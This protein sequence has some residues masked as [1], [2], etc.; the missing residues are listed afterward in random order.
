MLL[1]KKTINKTTLIVNVD[2]ISNYY[3][4]SSNDIKQIDEDYI[5][6][7]LNLLIKA[8][9]KGEFIENFKA[10]SN[11]EK[12]LIIKN[13]NLWVN[14]QNSNIKQNAFITMLSNKGII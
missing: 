8:G 4:N 6:N 3:I 10:I 9:K 13:D 7:N 12:E 11:K 14:Q 2:K 1:F 5:L